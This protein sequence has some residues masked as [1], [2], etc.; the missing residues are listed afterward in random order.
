MIRRPPRSTRT[1]TLFPYTTLVRSRGPA[2]WPSAPACKS[3]L[4]SSSHQSRNIAALRA[5][6]LAGSGRGARIRTGDLLLP[7]QTRYQPALHPVLRFLRSSTAAVAGKHRFLESDREY[8]RG[9]IP[10]GRDAR[11][12]GT[13]PVRDKHRSFR[14]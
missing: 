10:D 3:A 11:R 13:C 5:T 8:L 2:A 1:D 7:K 4:S 12:S 9:V 14:E 6:R